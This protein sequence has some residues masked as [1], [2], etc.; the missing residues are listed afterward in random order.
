[1]DTL[2]EFQWDEVALADERPHIV[3][4][5]YRNIDAQGVPHCPFKLRG[6][7][8]FRYNLPFFD[9]FANNVLPGLTYQGIISEGPVLDIS[10]QVPQG[11][12]DVLDAKVLWLFP[13]GVLR[14]F[15]A[16]DLRASVVDTLDEPET[17]TSYHDVGESFGYEYLGG[18]CDVTELLENPGSIANRRWVGYNWALPRNAVSGCWWLTNPSGSPEEEAKFLCKSVAVLRAGLKQQRVATLDK[19]RDEFD[20]RQVANKETMCLLADNPAWAASATQLQRDNLGA[21]SAFSIDAVRSWAQNAA[22]SHKEDIAESSC[23]ERADSVHIEDMEVAWDEAHRLLEQLVSEHVD[24]VHRERFLSTPTGLYRA[25]LQALSA[26]GPCEVSFDCW[27][28]QQMRAAHRARD[29]GDAASAN[30]TTVASAI[31]GGEPGPDGFAEPG[32]RL[33]KGYAIAT[34]HAETVLLDRTRAL[35]DRHYDDIFHARWLQGQEEKRIRKSEQEGGDDEK[36][37]RATADE[38]E[39]R[40]PKRRGAHRVDPKVLEAQTTRRYE[41]FELPLEVIAILQTPQDENKWDNLEQLRTWLL[42]AADGVEKVDLDDV[43][44][45]ALDDSSM[46]QQGVRI[47]T[48]DIV[49]SNIFFPAGSRVLLPDDDVAALHGVRLQLPLG[50]RFL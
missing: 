50:V 12:L 1:M 4:T 5:M 39:M 8:G 10:R 47:L 24:D 7:N 41:T 43:E 22:A 40:R 13:S 3:R 46:V 33:S 2:L 29:E 32:K 38:T 44:N 34:A 20:R 19:L 35:L 30:P 26:R 42:L 36:D 18:G 37:K 27:Q 45:K 49:L 48:E 16:R 25:M 9:K 11:G 15:S 14:T 6:C 21:P 31:Q 23:A 17:A 28:R